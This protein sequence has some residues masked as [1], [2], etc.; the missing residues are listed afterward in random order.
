MEGKMDTN[1]LTALIGAI[2]GLFGAGLGALATILATRQ[3]YALQRSQQ[4]A[5]LRKRLVEQYL[6]QLSETV[7]SLSRRV[8][9][10]N[11]YFGREAMTEEY[12]LS[13]SMYIIGSLWAYERILLVDG[14]YHE[15][16]TIEAGA[17]AKLMACLQAHKNV[18][19]LNYYDRL[20]LAELLT[21][22]EGERHRVVPF[23][24]FRQALGDETRQIFLQPI[25]EWVVRD[26]NLDPNQALPDLQTHLDHLLKI[27]DASASYSGLL[28]VA[29]KA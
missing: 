27:I 14:V 4:E 19:G 21:E 1:L 28:K 10:L 15:L 3:S 22:S 16:D 29:P 12:M 20:S 17:G 25:K 8:K 24:A 5:D 23:L 6:F 13:T 11:E 7:Y 2:S 9:N 26:T 18:M